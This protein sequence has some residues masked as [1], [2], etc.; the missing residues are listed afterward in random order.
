[1]IE[2]GRSSRDKR[3]AQGITAV[4]LVSLP[5]LYAVIEGLKCA[6][7]RFGVLIA[8]NFQPSYLLPLVTMTAYYFRAVVPQW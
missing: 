2:R 6:T 3:S 4:I 8:V 5:I 1:M 7:P